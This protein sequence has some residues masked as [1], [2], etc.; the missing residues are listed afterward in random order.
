MGTCRVAHA[1]LPKFLPTGQDEIGR[2]K[3]S[4]DIRTEQRRNRVAFLLFFRRLGFEFT[5]LSC[6]EQLVLGRA[7]AL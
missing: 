6:M 7:I 5:D 1:Q 4:F 2:V 3:E